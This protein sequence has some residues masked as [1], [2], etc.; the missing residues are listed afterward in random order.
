M[1]TVAQITLH[2][3]LEAWLI[4][5]AAQ[6]AV[7]GGREP[8][9]RRRRQDPA[10][11]QHPPRLGQGPDPVGARAQG[12]GVDT[13][14]ATDVQ[15]DRGRRWRMAAEQLPGP[16]V[17]TRGMGPLAGAAAPSTA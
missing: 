14:G 16:A 5:V 10:R 7:A 8:G 3:G 4:Q 15:H 12:Q 6:R 17:K 13:G 2:D 11:A 9:D 1:L